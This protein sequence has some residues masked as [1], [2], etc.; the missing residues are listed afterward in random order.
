METTVPTLVCPSCGHTQAPLIE[1]PVVFGCPNCHSIFEISASGKIGTKQ[2]SLTYSLT[3]VRPDWMRPGA[4]INYKGETFV[5]HEVMNFSTHWNEYDSEDNGWE[6]GTCQNMEYYFV[7]DA[8]AEL[9]IMEDDNQFFVRVPSKVF[10]EDRATLE[11]ERRQKG[12]IEYGTFQ[13]TAFIGQDDEP[14]NRAAWEY[15]VVRNNGDLEYEW[16]P[17]KQAETL[18][19]FYFQRIRLMELERMRVREESDMAMAQ[20][21]ADSFAFYRNVFGYT[22]LLFI[23]LMFYSGMARRNLSHAEW[24]FSI[25]ANELQADST[26]G[27]PLQHPMGEFHMEKG[28]AYTFELGC[29]FR[30][31]NMDADFMV[32]VVRQSDGHPVNTISASFYTESGTDSDGAW[33]ESTLKDKFR[34]KAE[35]SGTYEI[36]ASVR[37]DATALG[38]GGLLTADVYSTVLTRFFIVLGAITTLLWLIYQWK[39]EYAAIRGGDT[40]V[41]AWFRSMFH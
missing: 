32:Q 12:V 33:T 22:S 24:A 26:F 4:V 21:E 15:R 41:S 25:P 29:T 7:S 36:F 14:L 3:E 23:A 8:G 34:F 31:A 10:D 38:K 1:N 39:W 13:L 28:R 18:Q 20:E 9:C 2:R 40:R 6:S 30:H 5:L 35:E 16:E 19:A 17:G 11:G 37:P 27:D